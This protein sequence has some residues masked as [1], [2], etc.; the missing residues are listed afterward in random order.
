MREKALSKITFRDQILC[1]LGCC[2][3][4]I[5]NYYPFCIRMNTWKQTEL[6]LSWMKYKN[7]LGVGGKEAREFRRTDVLRVIKTFQNEISDTTSNYCIALLVAWPVRPVQILEK[8][9]EKWHVEGKVKPAHWPLTTFSPRHADPVFSWS[10]IWQSAAH[11]NARKELFCLT[12]FKH[13]IRI[14]LW[15]PPWYPI[16]PQINAFWFVWLCVCNALKQNPCYSLAP[17]YVS[18]HFLSMQNQVFCTNR[19]GAK[20]FIFI[21]FKVLC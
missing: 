2:C 15:R 10:P 6:A 9:E 12:F 16:V 4:G 17:S 5:C 1:F 11:K 7:H 19:L 18:T 21:I 14:P 8:I 20:C 3:Q 13:I